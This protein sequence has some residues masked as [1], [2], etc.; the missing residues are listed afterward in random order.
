VKEYAQAKG[1]LAKLGV[2]LEL[3]ADLSRENGVPEMA[4]YCKRV[5]CNSSRP[6]VDFVPGGSVTGMHLMRADTCIEEH[7]SGAGFPLTSVVP[8]ITF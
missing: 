3:A 6:H 4:E 1:V 5:P 2:A 8:F 7:A